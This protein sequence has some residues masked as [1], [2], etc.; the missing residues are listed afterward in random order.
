ML[1]QPRPS[2]PAVYVLACSD[3]SLYTGA[4]C[5][6][7]RR[8]SAHR[9]RNGA[10]YTRSRQPVELLAWWHPETYSAARSQEAKFKRLPRAAKLATLRLAEAYG[11]PI[12]RSEP[13]SRA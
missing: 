11:C 8:L 1:P 10:K 9:G 3:G 6:L 4:T 13:G 7:P 12:F 5:D 2:Q